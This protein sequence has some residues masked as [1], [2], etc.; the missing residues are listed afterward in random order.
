MRVTG[1]VLG[2]MMRGRGYDAKGGWVP[3]GGGGPFGAYG[4]RR[5]YYLRVCAAHI[6]SFRAHL[7]MAVRHAD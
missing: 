7:G 3:W 2:H 6:E 5:R 4:L 1:T